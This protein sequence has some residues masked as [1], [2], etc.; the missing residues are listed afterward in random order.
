MNYFSRPITSLG[1][2]VEATTSSEPLRLGSARV[3]ARLGREI[4]RIS[5]FRVRGSAQKGAL[6]VARDDERDREGD[7]WTGRQQLVSNRV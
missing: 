3:S 2:S 5:G 7:A 1:A 4:L 6:M